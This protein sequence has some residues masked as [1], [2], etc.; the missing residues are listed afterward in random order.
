M[1][2][3]VERAAEVDAPLQQLKKKIAD[4]PT[5]RSS[6][7]FT[8]GLSLL[9]VLALG[10]A[11]GAAGYWLWPQWQLLQQQQATV[12]Q[13]QQRLAEQSNQLQDNQ[14]QLKEQ[15]Q[16]EQQQRLTQLEQ[17]L[18]QQQQ[19]LAQQS[20]AQIQ[21]VRQLVQQRDSAPPRHWLL[22][23]IEYLLQ[24]AAQKVWLEQD[25]NTARALLSTADDKLAQLDDPSLVLVRQAI[26]ADNEQL[27]RITRPDLSKVH[28]ELQHMRTLSTS[29]ALKQQQQLAVPEQ[30]PSAELA[31]WRQTLSFYWHQS[32]SKLVQV[33]S[34]VPEDYF[35]LS[36]EQQLMLRMSLNQQLLLAELAALQH[37]PQVYGAALQQASDQLQRYFDPQDATV[38]QLSAQLTELAAIDV[39]LPQAAALKSLAQLQQYQ[40]ELTETGL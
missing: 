8:G 9:L 3:S 21:A 33:R 23:E 32:W 20:Q 38:Q 34:A 14:R 31:N 6:G 18:Q 1:S 13:N 7:S 11:A 37:Q 27:S 40:Q 30:A 22:A 19:Q 26:A 17:N 28:V 25:V 15:L 29:L 35:S 36:R 10:A 2:D 12:Q 39:S 4:E 16:V 24:L 5:T